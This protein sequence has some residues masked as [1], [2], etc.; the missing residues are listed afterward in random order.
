M[1]DRPDFIVQRWRVR[2]SP[3]FPESTSR[4]VM[5]FIVNCRHKRMPEDPDYKCVS[6]DARRSN[7]LPHVWYVEL[8]FADVG[9]PTAE[10]ILGNP[11]HPGS[12]LCPPV[13]DG[14]ILVYDSRLPP[15]VPADPYWWVVMI[16]SVVVIAGIVWAAGSQMGWW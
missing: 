2:G 12:L 6:Q 16:G 1:T 8:R 10:E 15:P 7:D 5:T 11:L 9:R 4:E 14:W 3:T 13:P